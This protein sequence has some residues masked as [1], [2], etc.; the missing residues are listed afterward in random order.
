MGHLILRTAEQWTVLV[1]CSYADLSNRLSE[2]YQPP[3]ACR[4]TVILILIHV[5]LITKMS[6]PQIASFVRVPRVA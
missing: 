1:T 2:P 3:A 6:L 4:L 5:M